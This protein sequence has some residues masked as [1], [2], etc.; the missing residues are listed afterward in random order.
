MSL[1]GGCSHSQTAKL[2][3]CTN[4]QEEARALNT[5]IKAKVLPRLFHQGF[6]CEYLLC[7]H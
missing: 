7:N 3:F 5:L 1:E 6:E 4:E 2:S